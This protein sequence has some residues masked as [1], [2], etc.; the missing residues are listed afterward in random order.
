MS[1]AWLF[2]TGCQACVLAGTD[3]GIC[4]NRDS[5]V[6][7]IPYCAGVIDYDRICVPK[8]SVRAH[9]Y[10]R[11]PARISCVTSSC[12]HHYHSHYQ[13]SFTNF[14]PKVKDDWAYLTVKRVVATRLA[15]END[16]NCE[17]FPDEL[18][19]PA[20]PTRITANAMAAC[21]YFQTS[22]HTALKAMLPFDLGTALTAWN[23][24]SDSCAI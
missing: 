19:A 2:L 23:H 1:T 12:V 8:P 9:C 18:G 11:G 10:P 15:I 3:S 4:M 6:N 13:L 5:I 24:T 22:I 7:S 20:W 21:A 14:T 16:P 17:W